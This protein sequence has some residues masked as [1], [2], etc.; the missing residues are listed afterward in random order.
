VK[1]PFSSAS[2]HPWLFY[3]AD[4]SVVS[5]FR[6]SDEITYLVGK[7]SGVIRDRSTR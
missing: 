1:N 3:P 6:R 4:T 5:A 7:A 2:R